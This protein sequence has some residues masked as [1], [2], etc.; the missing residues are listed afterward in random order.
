MSEIKKWEK[1]LE[2][3]S[4]III[5]DD[6]N[7]DISKYKL[8]FLESKL[9]AC[10]QRQILIMGLKDDVFASKKEYQVITEQE[11]NLILRLYRMY[12]FTDKLRV[13]A[14]S[15]QF[16]SM[17]NYLSTGIITQEEYFEALLH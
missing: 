15:P 5:F 12:E 3:Y 6:R 7:E 13:I 14:P 1:Y 16:G 9:E 4:S 2:E 11:Y 17:F 8:A 10:V